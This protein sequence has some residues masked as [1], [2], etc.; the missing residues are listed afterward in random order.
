MDNS[1]IY[2]KIINYIK[3]EIK[4]GSYAVD[5][6]LPTE[7]E[8]SKMF[9]TSR[10]TVIKA[11]DIL[12]TE[13]IIY[14]IQGKGSFVA[15]V[16]K[17]TRSSSLKIVSMIL[18]FKKEE[19]PRIEE[20]YFIRGAESFLKEEGYFLMVHYVN[21]DPKEETDI[22][23][24]CRKDMSDGI[25]VYPTTVANNI[26]VIYDLLL[27]NYPIVF[28]DKNV[29]NLSVTC[30]QS[31]NMKGGYEA[32]KYLLERGYDVVYYVSDVRID[33]VSSIRDRF[34]GYCRALKEAG[35]ILDDAFNFSG[36]AMQGMEYRPRN[37]EDRPEVYES[38]I[39]TAIDSNPGKRVAMFTCND[40]EALS[41]IKAARGLGVDMPEAFGIM[42]FDD[43][44]VAV[45]SPI[46]I[47]TMKQNFYKI[48][49]LSAQAVIE[50]IK[51]IREQNGNIFVDVKVVQ[52]QSTR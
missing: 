22:I 14:R 51:G 39:R 4:S 5:E 16:S 44:D 29:D 2:E 21:D 19:K 37:Y 9:N 49:K 11:M 7:A 43:S 36:Y 40:A 1:A 47:T 33:T 50:K 25:I 32:T 3:S 18:P 8:L 48:G 31:D 23:R 52:R 13:G 45:H 30:V 24:K 46:P 35:K 26:T 42:G 6:R 41:L 27:D 34:Y 17:G 15:D 28:I 20:L 38:M 10:T 12:N